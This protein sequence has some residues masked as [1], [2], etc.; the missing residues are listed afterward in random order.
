MQPSTT[1]NVRYFESDFSKLLLL[2]NVSWNLNW[3]KLF[4]FLQCWKHGAG[5]VATVD[6]E[7]RLA[8]V[9]TCVRVSVL[10]VAGIHT[11]THW[12]FL[13]LTSLPETW[14]TFWGWCQKP[15][16]RIYRPCPSCL[17]VVRFCIIIIF[18]SSSKTTLKTSPCLIFTIRYQFHLDWSV[19]LY[20]TPDDFTQGRFY[21]WP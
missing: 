18:N 4:C 15:T 3:S 21:F 19:C 16:Q 8:V 9:Y 20:W 12:S 17:T 5:P 1:L 10:R 2:T 13:M 14:L 11:H 7:K 6:S